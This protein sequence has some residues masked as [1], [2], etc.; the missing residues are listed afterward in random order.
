MGQLEQ[1]QINTGLSSFARNHSGGSSNLLNSRSNR[2]SNCGLLQV[3]A[4]IEFY[5][6]HET[7]DDGF[8][9]ALL[10]STFGAPFLNPIQ[11]R[12]RGF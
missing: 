1:T 7:C 2:K 11:L 5:H 6:F 12:H 3:V 8:P 4:V 9:I 10:S